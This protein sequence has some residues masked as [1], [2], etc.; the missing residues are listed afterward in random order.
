MSINYTTYDTVIVFFS[1]GKDSTAALLKLL[2]DGCPKHLIELWHHNVDGSKDEKP[3][4]DWKCTASYCKA[5]AKAM[6]LPIYFSW[7]EGGFRR[8]ML[9]NNQATGKV[10]FQ[11]ELHAIQVTGGKG[12][13]GTR[14]KFPQVSA[15][16]STRWCSAY[17]KIDVGT[18]AIRNQARFTNSR[19]LVVTGERGQESPA[20]AKYKVLEKD[21]AHSSTR[22][23][24]H[25]RPILDW[26]EDQVWAA[27]KAWSIRV[28]PAYYLGFGRVSCAFCIFGNAN[29]FV[30]AFILEPEQGEEVIGYEQQFGTT[31]KR[32]QNLP[33]L[34]ATGEMYEAIDGENVTLISSTNYNQEIFITYG[35]WTLPA[36][37]YGES[38]GP[39]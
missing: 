5:F 10:Y 26:T 34:M 2:D 23:V 13:P 21:R 3:F 16:L 31:I 24:D 19:T 22:H 9:R 14:L 8:E 15:D 6:G 36:G 12:K 7:R 1:G 4:M 39:I 20:R 11:N 29:Q 38:C 25:Y 18:A 33:Q 37:A 28:H 30:S 17:L 27:I 35:E 32:K